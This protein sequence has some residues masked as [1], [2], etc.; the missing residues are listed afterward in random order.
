MRRTEVLVVL[1]CVQFKNSSS[2]VFLI[3]SGR[4]STT[5]KISPPHEMLVLFAVCQSLF[6]SWLETGKRNAGM[7]I[8]PLRASKPLRIP[9][10]QSVQSLSYL[11]LLSGRKSKAGKSIPKAPADSWWA[12]GEGRDCT[13]KAGKISS[14]RRW[15]PTFSLSPPYPRKGNN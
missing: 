15:G 1:H 12:L 11:L 7:S 2:L 5:V 9:G 14:V 3:P 8:S 10:S 13:T 4:T 6:P